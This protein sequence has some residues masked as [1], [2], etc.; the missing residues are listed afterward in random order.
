MELI[1]A[2]H[3][4]HT[5]ALGISMNYPT[6]ILME[7]RIGV[8]L[9]RPVLELHHQHLGGLVRLLIFPVLSVMDQV[10]LLMVIKIA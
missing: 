8:V 1:T 5:G 6:Q 2:V 9:L 4:P 3:H 7:L 10:E